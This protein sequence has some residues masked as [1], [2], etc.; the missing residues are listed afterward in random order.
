MVLEMP[1]RDQP[2]ASDMGLRKTASENIE[3]AA[4]QPNSAPIATMTHP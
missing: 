2:V 1:V 4:T 3:P